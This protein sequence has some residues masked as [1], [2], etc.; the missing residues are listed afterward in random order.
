[1]YNL[2]MD[3]IYEYFDNF[4]TFILISADW[5]KHLSK[6]QTHK[7]PPNKGGFLLLT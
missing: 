4:H 6:K 5:F 3:G 1:M 7:R 2:C